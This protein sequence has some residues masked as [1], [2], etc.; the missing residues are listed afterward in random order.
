MPFEAFALNDELEQETPLAAPNPG[1]PTAAPSPATTF[2]QFSLDASPEDLWLDTPQIDSASETLRKHWRNAQLKL[3]TLPD[4]VTR[5]IS[6][7]IATDNVLTHVNPKTEHWYDPPIRNTPDLEYSKTEL[8]RSFKKIADAKTEKLAVADEMLKENRVMGR[9]I[10]DPINLLGSVVEAGVGDILP[11]IAGSLAAGPAGGASVVASSVFFDE[12]DNS[13][14][15]RGRTVNESLMD[16]SF[17][18]AFEFGTERL[19]LGKILKPG[20]T[21][22]KRVLK[23]TLAEGQQEMWTEIFDIGYN[24]G[25]LNETMPVGD[26]IQQVIAAGIVGSVMGG[27]VGIAMH[28]LVTAEEKRRL[29]EFKNNISADFGDLLEGGGT[30]VHDSPNN[31]SFVPDTT[32]VSGGA[33]INANAASLPANAIIADGPVLTQAQKTELLLTEKRLRKLQ[34]LSASEQDPG[35]IEEMKLE[36]LNLANRHKDLER[37]ARS[38]PEQLTLGVEGLKE[39]Q[40]TGV[41]TV[42][43]EEF[44]IAP[45]TDNDS[46]NT[47]EFDETLN[48]ELTSLMTEDEAFFEKNW[49]D[50]QS[51][52]DLVNFFSRI[53]RNLPYQAKLQ[54]ILAT[55]NSNDYVTLFRG[56][57]ANRP[58]FTNREVRT[59]GNATLDPKVAEG[60]AVQEE[61]I[62]E[63]NRLKEL[64]GNVGEVATEGQRKA[65]MAVAVER[66][67]V[68]VV[69]V[70][71][72][73]I[74]G[75]STLKMNK[76][77]LF[78]DPSQVRTLAHYKPNDRNAEA[79][80]IQNTSYGAG[81]VDVQIRNIPNG[82]VKVPLIYTD[83]GVP[84][85]QTNLP[86]MGEQQLK[87]MPS[88]DVGLDQFA[89]F[90]VD[91]LNPKMAMSQT[92]LGLAPAPGVMF[93][94]REA[95]ENVKKHSENPATRTILIE[96]SPQEFLDLASYL[97]APKVS[98][99]KTTFEEAQVE[100]DEKDSRVHR[101]LTQGK[102]PERERSPTGKLLPK[103]YKF[104]EIPELF[105][106]VQDGVAYVTGHEGRHRARALLRAGVQKMPVQFTSINMRFGE[107]TDPNRPGYIKDWPT[108]LVAQESFKKK[109]KMTV[110]VP[111]THTVPF[112]VQRGQTS[113]VNIDIDPTFSQPATKS[114]AELLENLFK[115]GKGIGIKIPRTLDDLMKNG[116][117]D[118]YNWSIRAGWTLSQLAK[119]NT[120][121]PGLMQYLE[122]VQAWHSKKGQWIALADQRIHEWM[123]LTTDRSDRLL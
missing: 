18:T 23:S 116:G 114:F 111:G 27:S 73:A 43:K 52:S 38:M 76:A 65:A 67:M 12:F 8:A 46:V 70:P 59:V 54:E 28:P 36:A 15:V 123:S 30:L 56:H 33:V 26:A 78:F 112:P 55:L 44:K 25:I 107:Q 50:G 100:F 90:S 3:A 9:S 117:M 87:E 68:S 94:Q 64:A 45:V 57:R 82:V 42:P 58:A 84:I 118:K 40:E 71:K 93:F 17:K 21:M 1:L 63:L 4:K 88:G 103:N 69:K 60:F 92:P 49:V 105:F 113:I 61:Y 106:N 24:A 121:I 16:A 62:R 14:R 7:I 108:V 74:R 20:G 66:A 97:P 86:G 39:K 53:K 13:N 81:A 34:D 89:L 37:R 101:L 5:T 109:G 99:D 102:V 41:F 80:R 85:P 122:T 32:A 95:L 6:G 83:L 98:M 11:M 31:F 48:A 96:M 91:I 29:E 110:L 75:A 72:A 2:E 79:P 104:A 22:A 35:K 119:A 19:A 47:V 115:N 51:P 120:H 10:L 77:E